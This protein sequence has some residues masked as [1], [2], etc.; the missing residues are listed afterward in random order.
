MRMR[1]ADGLGADRVATVQGKGATEPLQP[2][3]PDAPLNRRVSLVVLREFPAAGAA[4]APQP[5]PA[6]APAAATAP[7][8]P[9]AAAPAVQPAPA[10]APIDS[11]QSN[12]PL[13]LPQYK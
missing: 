5:T 8:P 2:D 6:A 7:P 4:P 10:P 1:V 11:G 13:G 12:A 9:P 3:A